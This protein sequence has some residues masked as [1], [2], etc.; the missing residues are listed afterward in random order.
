MA[1]ATA[2]SASTVRETCMTAGQASAN[3]AE[4]FSAF[5]ELTEDKQCYL[6]I[7][8]SGSVKCKRKKEVCFV[9]RCYA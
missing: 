8:F 2:A 3:S 7:M 5:T 1:K 4:F 6:L 9:S